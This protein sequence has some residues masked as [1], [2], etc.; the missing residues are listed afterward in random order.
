MENKL[1]LI[2]QIKKF[3]FSLDLEYDNKKI[4]DCFNLYDGFPF[5]PS[6]YDFSGKQILT[7][8]NILINK[9][10]TTIIN[11]TLKNIDKKYEINKNDIICALTGASGFKFSLSNDVYYFNQRTLKITSKNNDLEEIFLLLLLFNKQK[12]F[13]SNLATGSQK[14]ISKKEIENIFLLKKTKRNILI[15]K[16]LNKL[17]KYEKLVLLKKEFKLKQKKYFLENLFI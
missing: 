8:K 16:L 9:I 12:D 13:I 7:I 15:S 6:D 3:I 5:K 11:K 2:E 4:N 14:N 1:Q 17:I 10:D